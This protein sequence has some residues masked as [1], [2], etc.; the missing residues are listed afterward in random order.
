MKIYSDFTAVEKNL[1]DSGRRFVEELECRASHIYEAAHVA[2][3]HLDMAKIP[4]AYS[5]MIKLDDT[6][7]ALVTALPKKIFPAHSTVA[8][9]Q[10]KA[11]LTVSDRCVYSRALTEGENVTARK[12]RDMLFTPA[13]RGLNSKIALIESAGSNRAFE[14]FAAKL[15]GVG[16]IHT[17]TFESA[18]SAVS[19][20]QADYAVIPLYSLSDGRLDGLYRIVEKYGL[21]IIMSCRVPSSDGNVTTY[22]LLGREVRDID[23]CGASKL[24]IK[25]TLG[26]ASEMT[27]IMCAASFFGAEV[28]RVEPMPS[29]YGRDNTFGF[30]LLVEGAE[31]APLV[32]YLSL[33][34]SQYIPLGLYADVTE[35]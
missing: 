6:R 13:E 29:L 24:E 18:C 35:E 32:L 9:G 19:E 7:D 2:K 4:H 34:C 5:D 30:V 23:F 1:A 25:V 15:R 17:E 26:S 16:A 12:I 8:D 33:F 14:L 10:A 31:L 11:A 28:E 21:C 22:A 20:R 3:F 27:E